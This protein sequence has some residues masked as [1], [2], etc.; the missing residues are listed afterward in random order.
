MARPTK[1]DPKYCQVLLDMAREGASFTEFCAAIGICRKTFYNWRDEHEAFL[2]AYTRAELEGQAHWEK[3]L[4]TELMVDNKAN[5]PLVKLYFAN[6]FGWSDKK[7][8]ENRE[9]PHKTEATN[10]R[11]LASEDE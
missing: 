11:D 6:R 8:V 5:A 10:W 9:G 3:K 7:S 1:Y 4:R 2:H